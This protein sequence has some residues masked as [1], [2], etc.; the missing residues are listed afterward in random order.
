MS[1]PELARSPSSREGSY[2]SV[3][4]GSILYWPLKALEATNLASRRHTPMPPGSKPR[5]A[6]SDNKNDNKR[7][8]ECTDESGDWSSQ[9]DKQE[10][11]AHERPSLAE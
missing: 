11:F 5:L 4:I 9:A 8:S 2:S 1:W 7:N 3:S 6:E 10:I